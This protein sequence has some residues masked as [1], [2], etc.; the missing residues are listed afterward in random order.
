MNSPT[1]VKRTNKTAEVIAVILL[2][3]N[4]LTTDLLLSRVRPCT[5]GV[6]INKQKISFIC[7]LTKKK[8][9]DEFMCARVIH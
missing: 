9:N 8:L 6:E 5:E 2:R 7:F 3:C 4:T 1:N